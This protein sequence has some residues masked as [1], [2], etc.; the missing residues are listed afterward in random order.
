M[1]DP[2]GSAL[3]R[4]TRRNGGVGSRVCRGGRTR[5]R[6][7]SPS[8]LSKVEYLEVRLRAVPW[9]TCG[10]GRLDRLSPLLTRV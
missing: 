7:H 5:Q 8:T 4:R 9:P 3:A 1:T 2:C 6:R 10:A